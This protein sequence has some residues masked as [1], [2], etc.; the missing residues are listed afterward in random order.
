MQEAQKP[1]ARVQLLTDEAA[2]C[3]VVAAIAVGVGTFA[4]WYWWISQ[5]LLCAVTL[6]IN[7]AIGVAKPSASRQ[8][9]T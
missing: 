9:M 5:P 2:Q 6:T 7:T 3:L 8:A 4:V 1:K